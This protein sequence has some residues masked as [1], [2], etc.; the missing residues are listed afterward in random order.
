[1]DMDNAKQTMVDVESI[2]DMLEE[3]RELYLTIREEDVKTVK[4]RLSQAKHRR[5]TNERLRMQNGPVFYFDAGQET[6]VSAVDL[7][8]KLGS[9]TDVYVLDCRPIDDT[10]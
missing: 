6:Q 9:G 3:H 4:Q 7:Y 2:L 1:M 8:L 5:G 10:L